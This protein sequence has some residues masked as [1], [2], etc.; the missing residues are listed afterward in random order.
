MVRKP[1]TVDFCGAKITNEV[2]NVKSEE[3]KHSEELIAENQNKEE[4]IKKGMYYYKDDSF[5]LEH[6]EQNSSDFKTS[7]KVDEIKDFMKT[8]LESN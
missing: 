3:L 5:I 6:M 4:M 7:I 8:I 2:S 1:K